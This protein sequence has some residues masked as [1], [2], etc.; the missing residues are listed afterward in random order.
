MQN[1]NINPVLKCKTTNDKIYELLRSCNCKS[2]KIENNLV[3]IIYE[4][5]CD[6]IIDI[7]YDIN[8]VIP[9]YLIIDNIGAE[10]D[11]GLL[12][13]I[14]NINLIID[15]YDKIEDIIYVI[16]NIFKSYIKLYKQLESQPK[17]ISKNNDNFIKLLDIMKNKCL[18]RPSN[19]VKI[20]QLHSNKTIVEI[21]G[22]QILKIY[23]DSRFDIEFINDDLLSLKILLKNFN[24]RQKI[25]NKLEVILNMTIAYDLLIPPSIILT[26]NI[27]LKD[28]ILQLI[29]NMKPLTDNNT[30]S[31]KYSI[32][33]TV[34]NIHNMINILGEID[35]ESTS[36]I[37]I[38]INDLEYL[39]SIK[40]KKISSLQLSELFDPDFISNKKFVS[41]I[42]DKKCWKKGTG[43]GDENSNKTSVWDIDEYITNINAKQQNIGLKMDKL[44]QI[45]LDDNTMYILLSD[46]LYKIVNLFDSYILNNEVPISNIILIADILNDNLT[47]LLNYDGTKLVHINNVIQTVK[48]NLM[49][50]NKIHK[51]NLIDEKIFN[52]K[53]NTNIHNLGPYAIFDEWKFKYI[54]SK[55]NNFAHTK[56]KNVATMQQISKLYKEYL[57]LKK[58]IT[59][60]PSASMF[61][62]VDKSSIN[63]SRFIISGPMDTPYA[64]G[65]LIF[66]MDIPSTYPNKPP[67][68]Q[69]SNNGRKRFNPNLYECGKVCLSLLGTWAAEKGESWNSSSSTFLQ[70]LV[71]IQSLILVDEP[72]Y[73]EPGYQNNY[74]KKTSDK[75]N[76]YIRFY[77]LNHTMNDL[78][79]HI[80][81]NTNPYPEF[82][83]VIKNYFK[84]HRDNIIIQIT[85]WLNDIVDEPLTK[86]KYNY[87]NAAITKLNFQKSVD[88]FINLSSQL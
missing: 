79:E 70:I 82:E 81:L 22:D 53:I 6:Y 39:F 83:F 87:N 40:N 35:I 12:T 38:I 71:S 29:S 66:D 34:N 76:S 1:Y 11:I 37:D 61:F 52:E 50:S 4:I 8:T 10:I 75:Y 26:S 41:T 16:T 32:F 85:Q 45:L 18:I 33:D 2:Y 48:D 49:V 13:K 60:S 86:N 15:E 77:T 27:L 84:F 24:L 56:K 30:W 67:I 54:S 74:D 9:Q 58:S 73:N 31:I 55:F 46:N 69:F 42:K 59:I 21:L 44:L 7:Y 14:S 64:Y 65:L 28:D 47:Q 5:T 43:Y 3:K 17:I 72:F 88:K 25:N 23:K 78:I 19:I 51:I 80:V 63:K 36:P 57:I 20:N 68:V 62:L